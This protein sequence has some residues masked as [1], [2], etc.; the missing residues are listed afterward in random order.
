MDLVFKSLLQNAKKKSHQIKSGGKG[1]VVF[2]NVI[3]PMNVYQQ[4]EELVQSCF[5]RI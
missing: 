2:D 1:S 5:R 4:E 3:I